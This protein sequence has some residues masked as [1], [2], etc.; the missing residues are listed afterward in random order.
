MSWHDEEK[1]F[2]K[3]KMDAGKQEFFMDTH[4]MAAPNIG[5][6]TERHIKKPKTERMTS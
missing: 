6:S 5:T 3:G 1:T 2:T 4:Q